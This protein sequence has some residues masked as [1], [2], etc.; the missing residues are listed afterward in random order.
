MFIYIIPEFNTKK[1]ITKFTKYNVKV[2]ISYLPLNNAKMIKEMTPVIIVVN[3]N[4]FFPSTFGL[5]I[6]IPS[7]KWRIEIYKPH[8]INTKN[9]TAYCAKGEFIKNCC[10]IIEIINTHTMQT[11]ASLWIFLLT[12]SILSS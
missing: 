1:I 3:N 7:L 4:F 6:S 11:Y 9:S 8:P 5:K 12:I 2:L 10:T